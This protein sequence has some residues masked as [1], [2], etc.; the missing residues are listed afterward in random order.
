MVIHA[1]S[2]TLL[3]VKWSLYKSLTWP[4]TC[5][6]LIRL[7]ASRAWILWQNSSHSPDTEHFV[8]NQYWQL[9][10]LWKSCTNKASIC[11]DLRH[12]SFF[13][14]EEKLLQSHRVTHLFTGAKGSLWKSLESQKFYEDLKNIFFEE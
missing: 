14:C 2:L 4:H 9:I 13:S 1:K 10:I 8:E 7:W 5:S 6:N 11:F 3:K 12:Q